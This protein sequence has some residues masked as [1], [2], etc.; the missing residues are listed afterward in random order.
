MFFAFAGLGERET[1]GGKTTGVA[2]ERILLFRVFHN[3]KL[4]KKT[5]FS[6][7]ETATTLTLL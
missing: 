1:C 5:Y 7:G 4:L 6:A 3:E 2:L